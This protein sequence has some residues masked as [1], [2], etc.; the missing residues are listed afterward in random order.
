MPDEQPAKPLPFQDMHNEALYQRYLKYWEGLCL[1]ANQLQPHLFLG[2]P[3]EVAHVPAFSQYLK[4]YLHPVLP[5]DQSDFIEADCTAVWCIESTVAGIAPPVV[6][7]D[8]YLMLGVTKEAAV[9]S[10]FD[11][12][13]PAPTPA[14]L[15]GV[16]TLDAA[17][18]GASEDCPTVQ[19]PVHD[20]HLAM[21]TLAWSYILSA[22]WSET[23]GGSILFASAAPIGAPTSLELR[24]TETDHHRVR[25][26]DS[27]AAVWWAHVL[28]PEAGWL[29]SIQRFDTTFHSPWSIR[30]KS[31]APLFYVEGPTPLPGS[32]IA[33][34]SARAYSFLES[35]VSA[36]GL[37]EQAE[38]ALFA[39][40]LV[41]S[42]LR[43][44]SRYRLPSPC[45]VVDMF[46]PLT[47]REGRT[48]RA[49]S[50]VP[51]LMTIS[52]TDPTLI[53]RNALYNPEVDCTCAKE[54][55]MAA[56]RR[57]PESSGSAAV[58]GC[59]RSPQAAW[60][61]LAAGVTGFS[62]QIRSI[63]GEASSNLV[64]AAWTGITQGYLTSSISRGVCIS[65][66]HDEESGQDLIL[67]EEEMLALLISTVDNATGKIYVPVVADWKPVGYSILSK[68]TDTVQQV[69]KHS[70]SL[71]LVYRCLVWNNAMQGIHQE[72]DDDDP[73]RNRKRIATITNDV[74]IKETFMHLADW[75]GPDADK[76]GDFYID[77]WTKPW[78]LV[79]SE[80]AVSSG[81]GSM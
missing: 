14:V 68:S 78:D 10:T 26:H 39:T 79:L 29:A 57:W 9:F 4:G 80:S 34:D 24:E 37:A 74:A 72:F 76:T 51:R 32:Q 73:P 64:L 2:P 56:S 13:M 5:L 12:D 50:S 36:Y 42:H 18:Q 30:P 67:R 7:S 58:M 38:M 11:N 23:Q 70:A 65:V 75:R 6:Q 17:H 54:W 52:A 35:Y 31:T 22:H 19:T 63:S 53:L 46:P 55:A 8:Q 15:S 45:H 62:Q 21:L 20:N 27:D 16:R 69:A 33:P 40:L 60:W 71:R 49:L 44:N 25:T 77:E 43:R 59:L 1:T 81:V 3:I 41:P 47:S 66:K 28:A 61:W 48:L